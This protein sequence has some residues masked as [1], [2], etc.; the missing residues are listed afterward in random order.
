[1]LCCVVPLLLTSYV[2]CCCCFFYQNWEQRWTRRLAGRSRGSYLNEKI[3][4]FEIQLEILEDEE[5]R[6]LKVLHERDKKNSDT[7]NKEE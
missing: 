4:S 6:L 1:M 5:A 3:R 2:I 7:C